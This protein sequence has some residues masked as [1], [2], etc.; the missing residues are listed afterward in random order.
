VKDGETFWKRNSI[1]KAMSDKAQAF[2]E[3]EFS[4]ALHNRNVM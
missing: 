3:M 4:P 2:S 1:R